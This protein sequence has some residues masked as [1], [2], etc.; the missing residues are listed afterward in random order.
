MSV[1]GGCLGIRDFGRKGD[2]KLFI[3]DSITIDSLVV[4]RNCPASG[5]L[6]FAK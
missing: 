3:T 5:T 2:I 4:L 1:I 6:I